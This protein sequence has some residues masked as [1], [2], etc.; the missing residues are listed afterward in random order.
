MTPSREASARGSQRPR[1]CRVHR[2]AMSWE[3]VEE[4]ASRNLAGPSRRC[5]SGYLH[6]E[7]PVGAKTV[8]ALRVR[9]AQAKTTSGR[10]LANRRWWRH[11]CSG[12]PRRAGQILHEV[13][14]RVWPLEGLGRMHDDDVDLAGSRSR[15][16]SAH[17]SPGD[18]LGVRV[19]VSAPA[20]EGHGDRAVVGSPRRARPA[21]PAQLSRG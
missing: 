13:L 21:L 14:S 6:A 19:E 1:G 17:L 11:S 10:D 7:L 18:D 5:T 12:T 16:S 8:H 9:R 4:E 3:K 2:P 15:S 20:L